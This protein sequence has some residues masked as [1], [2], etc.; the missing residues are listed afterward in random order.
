MENQ[1]ISEQV[2]IEIQRVKNQFQEKLAEL[3]PLPDILKATQLKLQEEQ[4]CRSIADR[5]CDAVTRELQMYKDKLACLMNQ[6]EK[7]KNDHALGED[8]RIGMLSK[9]AGWEAKCAELQSMYDKLKTE[10]VRCQ[11]QQLQNE[12]RMEEKL[13]EITQ[14]TAQL[15]NVREESA[16]QV[17]SI[18]F[19]IQ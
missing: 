5:N 15:E 4:H 9:I 12:K 16:R 8:E 3:S 6:M 1:R 14:L 2:S 17:S 10:M 18:Y 11:E 19:S 7:Q 13:H